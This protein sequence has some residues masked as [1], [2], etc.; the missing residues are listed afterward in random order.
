MASDLFLI[1]DVV[2]SDI[3]VDLQFLSDA[4]SPFSDS[5]LDFLQAIQDDPVKEKPEDEVEVEAEAQVVEQAVPSVP[6]L[7][8]SPPSREME[9]LSLRRSTHLAV[10]E[11]GTGLASGFVGL[12]GLDAVKPEQRGVSLEECF[13]NPVFGAHSYG[14]DES[15]ARMMQRS[16]S[17]HSFDGRRGFLFQPGFNAPPGSPNFQNP[18]IR[19]PEN[20]FF[21]GHMRRVCSAGDLQTNHRQ[22]SPDAASFR[23]GRYS[24]EERKERIDK[25]RA[26]RTQRNFN[27]TI[28]YACR[29]TL[30]DSRPR[31]RGRFAR[32]DEIEETPKA[33]CFNAYEYEQQ[34][35][36]HDFHEGGYGGRAVRGG[37][38][39]NSYGSTPFQYYGFG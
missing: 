15:A 39:Y 17:S 22:F 5:P 35:W 29:K 12:S 13:Y 21:N 28:K 23:V 34:P 38:L 11:N 1:D 36:A 9:S 26:K 30:A 16:F 24:A 10:V 7:H 27:K 6:M 18:I 32:N 8:S 4:F 2:S 20:L 37:P 33:E 31:V 3:D 14:G 25:Y 19:S